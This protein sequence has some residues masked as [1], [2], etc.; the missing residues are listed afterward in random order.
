MEGLAMQVYS[1]LRVILFSLLLP[2][3]GAAQYIPGQSYYGTNNF[4][5]Y[6]PGDL[7]IIITAPH[8]G[9]LEPD[10]L[11]T[12]L[13]R[14]RDNGTQETT[15]ALMD[16]IISQSNGFRPHVVINHIFAGKMSA[17]DE[18]DSAA[19]NHPAARQ[20]WN[21]FHEFIEDAKSTV[22][23]GWGAGHYFE[24]HGNGHTDMWNEIGL[25]VSA[26]YLNGSDSLILSRI[27]RSTVRYLATQGG[28]NFLEIIRGPTSLG[29]LLDMRGWNSVPSPDNPAP[30]DGGFF[31]AGWNT[32][33]HGSRYEGT[34]DATHLENYYV[35]MQEANRSAYAG[36]LAASMLEFMEIHYGLSLAVDG[37]NIGTPDVYILHRNYPNPF[38]GSTRIEYE[39]STPSHVKLTI[40]D[41][42]GR[43][44]RTLVNT[45]RSTGQY[46][47]YWDGQN[48]SG[49]PLS[50]GVYFCSMSTG[51]SIR[52]IKMVYLR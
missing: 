6:I 28:M 46:T 2:L 12:I 21:E 18:I 48:D 38:N 43:L 22:T 41:S 45:P 17:T 11:P 30:G 15:L 47:Q 8:G 10:S 49:K 44:Q 51:E 29:G 52:T 34:I 40:F 5:E 19:G 4:I 7:P 9:Y 32:W 42:H 26:A 36:D 13:N 1:P 27:D 39:L 50:T 14:G 33:L 3:M 25:G 20:A 24:M 16:S 31:Y 37:E 35:F 23:L